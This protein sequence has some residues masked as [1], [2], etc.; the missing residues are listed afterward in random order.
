M[1]Y[2]HTADIH[3]QQHLSSWERSGILSYKFTEMDFQLKFASVTAADLTLTW[4]MVRVKR[5]F[6]IHFLKFCLICDCLCLGFRL[7]LSS[8]DS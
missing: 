4:V 6:I 7:S 3:V 2:F 8:L 5:R 1:A